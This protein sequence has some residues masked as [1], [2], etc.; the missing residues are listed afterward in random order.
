MDDKTKDILF[1]QDEKTYGADYKAHYM[2]IYKI[3]VESAEFI[4]SHRGSTN[5]FFLSINTALLVL[6]PLLGSKLQVGQADTKFFTG[7]A[8]FFLCIL[9]VCL[10]LSYKNLNKTKFSVI[11]EV[12]KKLP[13]SP[14]G[15]EYELLERG[16]NSDWYKPF[17]HIEKCVPIIFAGLYI[18]QICPQLLEML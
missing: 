18:W 16:D 6:L 7:I 5:R 12:E 17:T 2:D 10:L 15:T 4:S 14:Y 13:L 3:Y 9:W 11:H 1:S 8:G